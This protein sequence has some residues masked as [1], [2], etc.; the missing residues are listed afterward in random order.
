M[1]LQKSGNLQHLAKALVMGG[2]SHCD[3]FTSYIKQKH[4]KCK[5]LKTI[6]K[7]YTLKHQLNTLYK[8]KVKD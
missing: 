5:I 6:E 2:K 4:E 8:S 3:H 7:I 1:F